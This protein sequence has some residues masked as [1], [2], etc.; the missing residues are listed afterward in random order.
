MTT[1]H[2]E[3][4]LFP[5]R[6]G[7][8]LTMDAIRILGLCVLLAFA[9]TAHAAEHPLVFAAASLKPA[10]DEILAVEG[11]DGVFL[12]PADLSADMGYLGQLDHPEVLAAIS[13]ATRRIAA[14]G[15]APGIIWTDEPNASR[16]LAEGARFVATAID[17]I[18]LAGA[19]RDAASAGKALRERVTTGAAPGPA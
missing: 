4:D 13:D 6:R 2:S 16:A 3:H 5:E 1:D 11:V 14:A 15:K 18:A 10:L 9:T 8:H 12:G 7:T 17:V 19:M